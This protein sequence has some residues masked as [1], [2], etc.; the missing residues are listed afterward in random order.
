MRDGGA[1]LCG[2]RAGFYRAG[3]GDMTVQKQWRRPRPAAAASRWC[4]RRL[5][6]GWGSRRTRFVLHFSMP[7]SVEG[8]Y[9][10]SGRA[11]RDG[12]DSDCTL[13]YAPRDFARV[14]QLTRMPG[15]GKKPA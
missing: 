8:Y 2:V 13:M 12:L 6:W 3:M 15:R 5:R 4:T 7:K 11:G 9:Q 1:A 10:E 14:V